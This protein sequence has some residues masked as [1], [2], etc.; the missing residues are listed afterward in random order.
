MRASRFYQYSQIFSSRK[1]YAKIRPAVKRVLVFPALPL[2]ILLGGFALRLVHL[3][4][5]SLWYD[6]TVSVFLARSD[7][8]ELTRHTAADIHPPLYYYLLHFWGGL[9]GWSEFAVA[10]LSLWFGVLLIALVYRVARDVAASLPAR[11]GG[12]P[13]PYSALAALLVALSPYN[14]WY[15]QEV[16]MYTLG[17]AL[18]LASTYLLWRLLRSARVSLP[19]WAAY[20]LVTV[21]GLYTLYYFVFLLAFEW[22][23]VAAWLL[24]GNRQ[25][26]VIRPWPFVLRLLVSQVAI[27]LLYLPWLPIAFRQATDPPV[28]AW[29]SPTPLPN[30]VADSFS[31]L[32]LGESVDPA[33]VVPVLLLAAALI[34]YLLVRAFRVRAGNNGERGITLALVGYT[35]VPVLLILIASLRTPLFH[36][37][38]V[39]T[40]SPAF[41]ILLASGVSAVASDLARGRRAVRFALAAGLLGILAAASAYSLDNFWFNPAFAEDDLRGAVQRIAANWRPGDAI[42]VDA[43]YAYTAISYY[44]PGAGAPVRLS[45]YQPAPGDGDR[46]PLLLTTGSI[47]GSARLGWGDPRSDFYATSAD[48]TRAALD[49]VFASHPRV[50]LLRIYDTVTDPDG[51]IRDYLA[52]HGRLIDDAGFTGRSSLRVQ[53]YLTALPASLPGDAQPVQAGLAGRVM[54]LGYRPIARTPR[55]G[56]GE[57]LDTVLYWKPLQ[58]L[59][60]NYQ[61]SMQLLN[62]EGQV[63]AQ[64]DEKPLGDALPTS[65]WK[66][67]E[68]YPEPVRLETGRLAPGSYT[69]IVKL[70]NLDSGEVLGGPVTLETIRVGQ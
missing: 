24:I 68:I 31:A 44:D 46:S 55:N 32:V 17:A 37:R 54:L 9:A 19:G 62:A 57:W 6:E 11:E 10:F 64:Q 52:G 36:P 30:A 56:G 34:A 22:L 66:S 12:R 40:Y 69:A 70:Y 1:S 42:V 49:R 8:A 2:V 47:G 51:V 59:N 33:A 16:R 41:Y 38:Y 61:L 58:S 25:R 39:F 5:D 26:A 67:S 3:G 28:P 18:G 20:V 27:V 50:W 4:A 60:Y 53:G 7:L 13:L 43:G 48:E 29:R 45:S 21:L 65:R 14:V 23:A 63:A 15:S 35:L